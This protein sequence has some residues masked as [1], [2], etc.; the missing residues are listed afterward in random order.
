MP[1]T[2]SSMDT[3]LC[4]LLYLELITTGIPYEQDYICELLE[5]NQSD[6][7]AVKSNATLLQQVIDDFLTAAQGMVILN[8]REECI[9]P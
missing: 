4:I 5:D 7:N 9:N 3:N 8:R 1:T 6:V 2:V